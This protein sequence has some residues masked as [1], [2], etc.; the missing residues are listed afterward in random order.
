MLIRSV[1]VRHR[2]I[3]IFIIPDITVH[4][5]VDDISSDRIFIA[6]HL[7][8]MSSINFICIDVLYMQPVIYLMLGLA[9]SGS[10]FADDYRN[11]R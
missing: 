8:I 1:L 2:C 11:D 10:T 4:R 7:N 3:I 9:A 5:I 6:T